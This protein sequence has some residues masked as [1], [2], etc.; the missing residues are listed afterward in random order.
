MQDRIQLA[1]MEDGVTVVDPDNTWIESGAT[2]GADT[3]VYP[4]T[5]IERGATV[6]PRCRI[7]PF[8]RVCGDESVPEGGE[9]RPTTA[10]EI[11][12]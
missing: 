11:S 9:I 7:G 4:F 6:G 2:I 1:H 5:F 12:A 8:V 3:V 10:S